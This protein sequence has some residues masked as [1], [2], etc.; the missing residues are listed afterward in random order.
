MRFSSS[1][2]ISSRPRHP[3]ER[4]N[5]SLRV[6]MKGVRSMGRDLGEQ[7]LGEAVD[8]QNLSRHCARSEAIRKSARQVLIASSL[9]LLAMAAV[10]IPIIKRGQ[11]PMIAPLKP[12]V[13][14]AQPDGPVI[15]TA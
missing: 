4:M 1:T 14:L 12:G 11:D 10:R 13:T 9:A 6:S 15:E 7:D 8:V 2:N 5:R 3:A